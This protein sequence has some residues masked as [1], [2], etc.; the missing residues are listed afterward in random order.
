MVI[1]IPGSMR[2][3]SRITPENV[4]AEVYLSQ[5]ILDEL[6]HL[7]PITATIIQTFIE[8][9]GIEV[10]ERW[11]RAAHHHWGFRGGESITG[12]GVPVI[13]PPRSSSRPGYYEFWGHPVGE[14]E[15]LIAAAQNTGHRADQSMPEPAVPDPETERLTREVQLLKEENMRL[16]EISELQA[17]EIAALRAAEQRREEEGMSLSI[18]CILMTHAFMT[19]RFTFAPEP[20]SAGTPQASTPRAATPSPVPTSVGSTPS[21]DRKSSKARST[22]VR[23]PGEPAARTPTSERVRT[24]PV[25]PAPSPTKARRF[26]PSRAS[27]QAE[28]GT[29]NVSSP[30]ASASGSQRPGTP[31]G[32]QAGPRGGSPAV[33]VRG[34]ANVTRSPLLPRLSNPVL[35]ESSD[36]ETESSVTPS[37]HTLSSRDLF[38]PQ[39]MPSRTLSPGGVA[40][41]RPSGSYVGG[42]GEH[43]AR[44]LIALGYGK[45]GNK[46]VEQIFDLYP[47]VLWVEELMSALDLTKVN[48]M[49]L[50]HSMVRDCDEQG[51]LK[52][53]DRS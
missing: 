27:S 17:A 29:P 39:A 34:A 41:T 26:A 21:F 53:E 31:L 32:T 6:P 3:S 50:A 23:T 51:L 12:Q 44:F 15:E 16:R 30:K 45:F 40:P 20:P 7:K 19:V 42:L 38:S 24:V 4:K 14:L 9:I 43:S 48:A 2:P 33:P 47:S 36:E 5:Y 46:A 28:L 1:S 11:L 25:T 8:T 52:R 49:G 35:I 37:S 13:F 18:L 10:S 22:R